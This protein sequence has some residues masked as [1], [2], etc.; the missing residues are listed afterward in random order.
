MHASAAWAPSAPTRPIANMRWHACASWWGTMILRDFP[1]YDLLARR[2]LLL[3][4]A[5]RAFGAS[6]TKEPPRTVDWHDP[7]G[8]I[9]KRRE[10]NGCWNSPRP[11]PRRSN[12][13]VRFRLYHQFGAAFQ[14]WR[15][16]VHSSNARPRISVPATSTGSP[17]NFRSSARPFYG[18]SLNRPFEFMTSRTETL[19]R[20]R[21]HQS[22]WRQLLIETLSP[23][24]TPPLA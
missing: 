18:I 19:E 3:R 20:L 16:G 7:C 10:N 9:S 23:P 5:R 24:F 21:N 6:I 2:L 13:R 1:G 22:P 15:F 17:P 14:A 11:S 4:I 12:R 8:G